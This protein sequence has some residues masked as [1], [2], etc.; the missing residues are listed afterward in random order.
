MKTQS[1]ID[2]L[3]KKFHLE[4]VSAQDISARAKVGYLEGWVSVVV[5]LVLFAAKFYAGIMISSISIIA[6]AVHTLSDVATSAVVIWG[7][8]I[9]QKPAD[10]EHPF[11]HGRMEDI[12]TLIIA[13]MLCLVGLELVHKSLIRF[14][15]PVVVMGNIP[16]VIMLMFCALAKEWMARFSFNLGKKINS[17]TLYADAWHH[18]SDAVSTVLV[19]AAVVGSMFQIFRLDAVF[20][21]AVAIYIIYTGAVLVRE[22]S[23]HL[24]GRAVDKD[25]RDMIERIALSVEGVD[26]VHDIIAHDYG[27]TKA[28]SLHIEIARNLDSLTAHQIAASVETRIAKKIKSSPIVH[29]DLKKGK[30]K[31]A[32]TNFRIIREI[33]RRYSGIINFHGVEILSNESGDFL[34]LDIVVSKWMKIEDSH[35]LEHALAGALKANFENYKVNIHVEPCDGRCRN[36]S[37]DCKQ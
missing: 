28:I 19:I 27:T 11:G 10:E 6:D 37:Q 34:T 35:R 3:L 18:R 21:A 8:K 25:L 20:G 4:T 7:F 5:N 13:V 29:V 32:S 31:K 26:G 9:S 17:S 22:S 16:V 14:F 23:T 36:C 15:N 12:A 30:R 24:L 33:V 1:V 2:I